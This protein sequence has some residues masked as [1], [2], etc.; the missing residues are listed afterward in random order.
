[1]SCTNVPG[2]AVGN[3]VETHKLTPLYKAAAGAIRAVDGE[4]P[5]FFEPT[6]TPK[7]VDVFPE[8]P[9]GDEPQQVFAYHIYCQAGDGAG[10]VASATCLAAQD[11]FT[12][13]YY[14]FLRKNKRVAG[15]MTEFGAIGGSPKELDHLRRLL[16]FADGE[17][18][19]WTYWMLKKYQDFTTANAAES[20]YDE[21]G[22]LE[23]EKLKALSRTYAP[24]I[25]GTPSRMSFDPDT[26]AFELTFNATLADAATEVYL[27]EEL[28]YPDGY[29]TEVT[30]SSC[31]A[32]TS[33]EP[34][35]LHF[36]LLPG[37]SCQGSTVTVRIARQKKNATEAFV[38]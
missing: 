32:H 26:G 27:N 11:L 4:T 12:H 19:S 38:I 25:A 8:P 18:Q 34:N 10:P 9:L 36:R 6:V 23:V 13:S 14:G 15:F 28:N 29:T 17:M 33:P 37:A 20:L 21:N 1:M 22:N 30:P 16:G 3:Y 5:I 2:V 35:Y 24:A 31:L 7:L